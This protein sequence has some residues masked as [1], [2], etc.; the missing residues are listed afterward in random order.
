[1]GEKLS[2]VSSLSLLSM[3]SNDGEELLGTSATTTTTDIIPERNTAT[4]YSRASTMSSIS[5]TSDILR[6]RDS[7]FDDT[8]DD[9]DLFSSDWQRLSHSAAKHKMAI[10]PTKK[11]GGPSRQHRRTLEVSCNTSIDIRHTNHKTNPCFH[12][13]FNTRGQ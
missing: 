11:K 9:V 1:M 8:K 12:L 4:R 5:M 6:H 2:E 13:D 10:R 3:N 7:S